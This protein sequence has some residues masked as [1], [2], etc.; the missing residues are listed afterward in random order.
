MRRREKQEKVRKDNEIRKGDVMKRKEEK[1]KQIDESFKE[2]EIQEE[3]KKMENKMERGIRL[4]E[5]IENKIE[6]ELSG[7]K[8]RKE[9][10]TERQNEKIDK[11][12]IEKIRS[13]LLMAIVLEQ[14]LGL[15]MQDSQE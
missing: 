12:K 3:G 1:Q 7:M 10:E 15:G 14:M 5:T 11:G 13:V 8:D 9:K 2:R 4:E 6:K